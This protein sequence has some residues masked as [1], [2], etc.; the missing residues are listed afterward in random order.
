MYWLWISNEIIWR[1]LRVGQSLKSCFPSCYC[2]DFFFIQRWT[3]IAF[4]PVLFAHLGVNFLLTVSQRRTFLFWVSWDLKAVLFP[5]DCIIG[6]GHHVC[7][8]LPQT[9]K[10]F[11]CSSPSVSYLPGVFC[12]VMDTAC[13]AG[14]W[15]SAW[16]TG[17]CRGAAA[18]V[19]S[20]PVAQLEQMWGTPEHLG[21]KGFNKNEGGRISNL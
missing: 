11:F 19:K 8:S 7:L 14:H 16:D 9:M 1:I 2:L 4:W 21:V 18:A 3:I 20:G 5:A 15:G 13:T 6:C 10:L 17:A 12:I